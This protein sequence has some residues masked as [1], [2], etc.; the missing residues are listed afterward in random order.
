MKPPVT[1]SILGTLLALLGAGCSTMNPE[2]IRD[3]APLLPSG[4]ETLRASLAHPADLRL[5][6][7]VAE[8]IHPPGHPPRLQRH[9]YRVDAEY[10]YPASTVKLCAAVAALQ[11]IEL[12]QTLHPGP[13][14]AFVPLEIA[15]LFPGDLPQ[16]HDPSNL[17]GGHITVAHEIRKISLVSDNPAFNR[18]FDLVGHQQLNRSMHDLGLAS[19]VINH[20]LSE[21]RS[22]PNPRASAEVT[23]KP[24]AHPP[25]T[26]PARVS[27]LDLSHH[28]PGR[29]VGNAHLRG[30]TRVDEP[31]DFSARNRISLVDLQ[32]LMVKVVR[33]DIALPGS[34]LRLTPAHRALLVDSMTE[35]PR[36]SNNPRYSARDFPDEYS[37]FLLPGVRRVFPDSTPGRRIEIT[38][39]IGRAYGFSIE[40]A[41][42]HNPANGRSVFVTAALY[43][44][45]DGVLNDDQYEYTSL[46]DPLLADLGELIARRWLTPASRNDS[47]GGK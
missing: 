24:A 46:A 20:R 41:H 32:N 30:Q 2:P 28:L 16:S 1:L 21:T 15:P 43:T 23:F 44:N 40:N 47:V 35:Y 14:L 29:L 22:I 19:V 5:Q 6:I 37:K 38:G 9:G 7:L 33:P 27:T 12:L 11:S 31:M 25:I 13:D 42:L 18:L 10:F 26:V 45:S 4:G 17:D 8:V 39:K 36:E 3:L 34:S